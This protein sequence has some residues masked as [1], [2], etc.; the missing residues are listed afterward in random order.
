LILS[1]RTTPVRPFVFIQTQLLLATAAEEPAVTDFP[2]KVGGEVDEHSFVL[3]E[4]A[5]SRK[6]TAA[7]ILA[8]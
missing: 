2:L 5:K 3:A 6:M 4:L 1:G 8:K 7:A